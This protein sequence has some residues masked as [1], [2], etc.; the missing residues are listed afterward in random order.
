MGGAK[1]VDSSGY[2]GSWKVEKWML[3]GDG[4]CDVRVQVGQ[5]GDTWQVRSTLDLQYRYEYKLQSMAGHLPCF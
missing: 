3:A 2:Q 4:R 1:R 5:M